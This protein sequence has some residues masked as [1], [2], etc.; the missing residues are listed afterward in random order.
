MG[1]FEEPVYFCD[2]GLI[3]FVD[4]TLAGS[5]I[6][7]GCK[8]CKKQTKVYGDSAPPSD[9]VCHAT[10]EQVAAAGEPDKRESWHEEGRS[11]FRT[12]LFRAV[13]ESGTDG[14]KLSELRDEVGADEKY[15][16]GTL[17]Q[18]S[19][20]LDEMVSSRQL[21]RDDVCNNTYRASMTVEEYCKATGESPLNF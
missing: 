9:V 21:S 20:A 13:S 19:H 11:T 7:Y 16:Y 3:D 15:A 18:L 1:D 4:D 17:T 8:V 12:T 14:V 5:G 10:S 2:F 6:I